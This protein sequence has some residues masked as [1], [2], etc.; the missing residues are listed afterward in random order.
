[1]SAEALPAVSRV[2]CSW[3]A[4]RSAGDEAEAEG[5]LRGCVAL[6]LSAAAPTSPPPALLKRKTAGAVCTVDVRLASP[7]VFHSVCVRAEAGEAV[8]LEVDDVYIA[9]LR[10]AKDAA[11]AAESG[12]T[13]GVC[14]C[15]CGEGEEWCVCVC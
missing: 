5:A 4:V 1:M 10:R 9:T 11:A 6:S 2:Q 15:V 14:V 8:E 3:A 12:G 13:S 7:A